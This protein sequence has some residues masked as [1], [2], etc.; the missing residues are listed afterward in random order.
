MHYQL[1]F[2]SALLRLKYRY[3]E[4]SDIVP[5]TALLL[6]ASVA[7]TGFYLI[8]KLYH[9]NRFGSFRFRGFL[10]GLLTGAIGLFLMINAV[11]VNDEVRV[12]L[13]YLPLVLLAFYGA[14]FPLLIATVIVASTRFLFG[15]TDQAVVAFIATFI[16]SVGM[17]W[18]HRYIHHLLWQSMLLHVWALLITSISILVNLGWNTAYVELVLTFWTVGLVVG[19]LASLLAM[20]LEQATRRAKAYKHSAERDHLTGLFNRR[21]WEARTESLA[22]ERRVYNVLALDID[23]FKHVNDTYGHPNG[24]LVLK[25]FA[26]LLNIETRS[27]D[28]VARIGGEEF[29]IL[30]YD[31]SPEKVA[32]VA[33][34]IRKRIADEAFT[35]S[36][37]MTIQISVSIGIA[38]GKALPVESMSS[39]A[40][41][42]LYEAKDKGRNRTVVRYVSTQMF[43][44]Q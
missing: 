15:L 33:E 5:F 36:D 2:L 20:D 25:R 24:D 4:G 34:R 37:G 23:H 17:W 16:I 19:T 27:H 30:I 12:D 14:R 3:I 39:L 10:I 44:P 26:E 21:M 29:V 38:H 8:S 32:K 9:A 6:N 43:A 40:D 28:I 13:R 31:L 35:L 42:A 1:T 7:F 41:M 18:I 22:S 11:Q